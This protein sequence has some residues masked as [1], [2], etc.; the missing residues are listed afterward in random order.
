MDFKL[1]EYLEK[2][3]SDISFF[4]HL[5]AAPLRHAE[6]QPLFSFQS[7]VRL[8]LAGVLFYAGALFV[9]QAPKPV[10]P[11]ALNPAQAPPTASAGASGNSIANSFPSRSF[12]ISGMKAHRLAP[13]S[14]QATASQRLAIHADQGQNGQF[15]PAPR[16][17]TLA[18]YIPDAAAVNNNSSNWFDL[19][20]AKL[21]ISNNSALS[22]QL[23]ELASYRNALSL[24]APTANDS[25]VFR[26]I[27]CARVLLFNNDFKKWPAIKLPQAARI[28]GDSAKIK[29]K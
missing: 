29:N 5:S 4:T 11:A 1:H 28:P 6:S 25:L 27:Y 23:G 19:M 9:S 7:K 20:C 14:D 3:D 12:S 24:P 17:D 18:F 2:L 10:D 16:I 8:A 15:S 26:N 22:A 13:L 21:E